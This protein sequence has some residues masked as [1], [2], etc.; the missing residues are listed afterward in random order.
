LRAAARV[1]EIETMCSDTQEHRRRVETRT[2]EVPGLILPSWQDVIDRDYHGWDREHVVIDTAA[3]S[4][5][6]CVRMIRALL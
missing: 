3:R 1:V 6:S 2:S 4:V 5:E